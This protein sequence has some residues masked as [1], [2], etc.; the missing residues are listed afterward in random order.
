M[1]DKFKFPF[2]LFRCRYGLAGL[3]LGHHHVEL[4]LEQ[5]QLSLSQLGLPLL[6]PLLLQPLLSLGLHQVHLQVVKLL[7]NGPQF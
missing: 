1:R 3:L 6:Q 7:Q 2:S 4:S 5:S